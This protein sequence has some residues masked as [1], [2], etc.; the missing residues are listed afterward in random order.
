MGDH[1]QGDTAQFQAVTSAEIN[2]QQETHYK[3]EKGDFFTGVRRGFSQ[4]W[5]FKRKQH[6]GQR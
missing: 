5:I 2:V 3:C 6:G 4:E 1:T